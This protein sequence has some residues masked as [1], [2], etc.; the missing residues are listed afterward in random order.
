MVE[1]LAG[2]AETTALPIKRSVNDGAKLA[3]EALAVRRLILEAIHAVGTGHPGSSLSA[4]EIL[5]YLYHAHLRIDPSRPDWPERDWMVFSKGHGAPALYAVLARRGYFPTE[6]LASLRRLGSPLQGH[7]CAGTALGVDVSTGSLGQGLSFALGLALGFRQDGRANRVVCVVGDGELQEGQ[8]WEAMM[9]AAHYAADN[10][11]VVVDC[12]GLQNDGP[13]QAILALGD[14]AEKARAFG[15]AAVSVDGHDFDQLHA[16]MSARVPG[17]P[18]LVVARTIK[19]KG[20][21][22]ME[23]VVHWHHHPIDAD[24]FAQAMAELA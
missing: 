1:R 17:R 3:R 4:V 6:V 14:I 23:G 11:A 2:G 10:L 24:Q 12:N 22:F 20:V 8:N 15:W 18:T 16:A 9:A 7:P 19:G 5:V 13:T 21:S